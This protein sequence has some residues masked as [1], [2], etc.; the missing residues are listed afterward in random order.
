MFE[1]DVEDNF[2]H[3]FETVSEDKIDAKISQI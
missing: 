2:S 1:G 3:I